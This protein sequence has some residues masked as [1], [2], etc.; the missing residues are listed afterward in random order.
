MTRDQNGLKSSVSAYVDV[1]ECLKQVTLLFHLHFTQLWNRN[2]SNIFST[3]LKHGANRTSLEVLLAISDSFFIFVCLV[4]LFGLVSGLKNEW[5]ET[6]YQLM[7]RG[8]II[9]T[10]IYVYIALL[11]YYGTIKYKYLMFIISYLHINIC[12]YIHY[13]YYYIYYSHNKH[14]HPQG[15]ASL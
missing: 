13:M 1:Y 6:F 8:C 10:F 12:I 14:I 9:T 2:Y 15:Q 5:V 7:W 3:S 4:I 11:K